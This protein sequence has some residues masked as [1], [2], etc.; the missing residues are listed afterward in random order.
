MTRRKANLF[1]PLRPAARLTAVGLVTLGGAFAATDAHHADRSADADPTVVAA[2]ASTTGRI[3]PAEVLASV[4]VPPGSIAVP[5][6]PAGAPDGGKTPFI[7]GAFDQ[8][9][10]AVWWSTTLSS[11]AV[12]DWFRAH[13]PTGM[14]LQMTGESAQT[15]LLGF[16]PVHASARAGE[17]TVYVQAFSLA[18]GRT[19][20]QLTADVTYQPVRT[21]QELVPA[22]AKLIV[23]V[24]PGD[25]ESTQSPMSVTVTD[26]ARI[27]GVTKIIN[28]L[29][30]VSGVENCPFDDGRGLRL[31][32]E[33]AGGAILAEADMNAAGCQTTALTIGSVRA[34]LT[35]TGQAIQGVENAIGTHWKLTSTVSVP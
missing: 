14:V 11:A 1:A 32:F 22:A 26:P 12:F 35:D 33:S 17:P 24:R 15:P 19:G 21:T 7:S 10:G 28:A 29:P 13:P 2:A 31:T 27:A 30:L 23:T 5:E 20:I 16:V 4:P 34:A 9:T 25:N 3:S 6:K 18:D 8:R